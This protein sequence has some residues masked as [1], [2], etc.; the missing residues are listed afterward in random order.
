VSFVIDS[1]ADD[2]VANVD[3]DAVTVLLMKSLTTFWIDDIVRPIAFFA[4]CGY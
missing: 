2:P 3:A 1:V 4:I